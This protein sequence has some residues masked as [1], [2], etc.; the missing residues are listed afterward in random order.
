MT[1]M[2]E[3]SGSVFLLLA[4]QCLFFLFYARGEQGASQTLTWGKFTSRQLH[5]QDSAM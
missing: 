1:V 3:N 2:R 4:E 5:P